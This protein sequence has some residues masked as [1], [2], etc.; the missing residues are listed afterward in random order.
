MA[1][2]VETSGG[3][4]DAVKWVVAVLILTAATFGNHYADGVS[5][6]VKIIGVVVLTGMAFAIALTTAKGRSFLG[7]LREARVEARKIVWPGRQETWQTTLIVAGVVILTSLLLWG[8]DSLFGW[9]VSAI[10]GK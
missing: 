1:T 4:M 5:P 7:L 6:L 2:Q 8:I 9:I 3:G 10:I